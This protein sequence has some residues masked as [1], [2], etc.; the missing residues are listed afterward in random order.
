MISMTI[1]LMVIMV[2]F[3]VRSSSSSESLEEKQ[4]ELREVE[5]KL[6]FADEVSLW[7]SE[8][9]LKWIFTMSLSVYVRQE[10]ER[11]TEH[12]FVLSSPAKTFTRHS[13]EAI[14]PLSFFL[15][16]FPAKSGGLECVSFMKPDRISLGYRLGN[17]YSH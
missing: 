2:L 14:K 10:E 7:L 5:K 3:L 8:N 6:I 4:E 9:R 1:D 11:K 13:T 15:V 16:Y 12:L 17:R